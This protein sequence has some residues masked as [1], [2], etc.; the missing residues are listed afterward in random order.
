FRHVLAER[1]RANRQSALAAARADEITLAQARAL[2]DTDP[3]AALAWLKTLPGDSS[4]WSEARGIAA[5]AAARG[6]G[7]LMGR[8]QASPLSDGL[9]N[10]RGGVIALRDGKL[11]HVDLNTFQSEPIDLDER[12]LRLLASAD[13]SSIACHQVNGFTSIHLATGKRW[14][15]P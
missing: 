8:S 12:C 4:R 5:D 13:G 10:T 6:V 2:L 15:F 1:D 11:E 7:H 14:R 3:T 9:W